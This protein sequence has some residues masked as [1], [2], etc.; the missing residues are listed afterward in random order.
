MGKIKK[1]TP[2]ERA[3]QEANQRRLEELIQRRLAEEAKERS[4]KPPAPPS[5]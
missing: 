2:E 4:S 3:R 1:M 5:R